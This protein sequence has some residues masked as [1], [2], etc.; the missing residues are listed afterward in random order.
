MMVKASA[1]RKL[2]SRRD[3]GAWRQSGRRR[4]KKTRR[5]VIM[6]VQVGG[7]MY[8]EV[9]C[10]CA[11]RTRLKCPCVSTNFLSAF[12]CSSSPMEAVR[13]GTEG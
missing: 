6:S 3:R 8:A 13:E 4:E 1:R 11:H 12:S 2:L 9:L 5:G 10:C 7:A